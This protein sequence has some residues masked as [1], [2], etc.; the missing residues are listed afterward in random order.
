MLKIGEVFQELPNGKK[1]GF[2]TILS[3]HLKSVFIG[4]KFLPFERDGI[5]GRKLLAI[6]FVL[7]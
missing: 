1:L 2:F 6:S 4:C 3:F 5:Q 7:L